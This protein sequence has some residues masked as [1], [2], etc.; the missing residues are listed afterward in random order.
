MMRWVKLPVVI[1]VLLFHG[2]NVVIIFSKF[3]FVIIIN[4]L[5]SKFDLI[6]AEILII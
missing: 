4:V 1:I 2:R 3:A 6:L 5:W